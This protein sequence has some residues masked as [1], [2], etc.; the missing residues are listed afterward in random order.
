MN[1]EIIFLIGLWSLVLIVLLTVIG[2]K[3]LNRSYLR[4]QMREDGAEFS[5][6]H[7]ELP[8]FLWVF[9]VRLSY[10]DIESV[11]L[12]PFTKALISLLCLRY[13][14]STRLIFTRLFS[15]IVVI[16]LKAP[17]FFH[18]VMIT[19]KNP[20]RFVEQIQSRIKRDA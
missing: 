4:G 8:G 3:L 14:I 12:V 2:F 11:Q 17:H 19:P 16:K 7:L 15:A 5:A 20:S 6:R 10:A 1:R 13:G 9:K 18:Y